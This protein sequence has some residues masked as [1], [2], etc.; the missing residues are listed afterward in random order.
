MLGTPRGGLLPKHT[1]NEIQNIHSLH[2]LMTIIMEAMNN[3]PFIE[4]FGVLK[5]EDFLKNNN[6]KKKKEE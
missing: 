5:E 1:C 2:F 3:E 4:M 6:K